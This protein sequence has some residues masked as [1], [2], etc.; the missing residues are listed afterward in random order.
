MR[1]IAEPAFALMAAAP[2]TTQNIGVMSAGSTARKKI[3]WLKSVTK[4]P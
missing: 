2:M 3:R 1:I 4:I